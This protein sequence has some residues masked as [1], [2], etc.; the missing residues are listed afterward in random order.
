MNLF[1]QRRRTGA[2][3]FLAAIALMLTGCAGG[4]GGT[5]T[6]AGVIQNNGTFGGAISSPAGRGN[7]ASTSVTLRIDGD[8]GSA[9]FKSGTYGDT[10]FV[11]Y[12]AD[13]TNVAVTPDPG[14]EITGNIQFDMTNFTPGAPFTSLH[15]NGT[16]QWNHVVGQGAALDIS[17]TVTGTDSNG[18]SVSIPFT[19][20]YAFFPHVVSYTGNWAGDIE[21]PKAGSVAWGGT[22]TAIDDTHTNVAINYGGGQFNVPAVD[23]HLARRPV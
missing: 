18:G 15:W 9:S 22:F 23:Q 12:S 19:L 21:I 5:S 4:G 20:D 13:I 1:N 8:S 7:S 6:A 17:G 10:A 14:D 2:L 16:Y 11:S 3:A